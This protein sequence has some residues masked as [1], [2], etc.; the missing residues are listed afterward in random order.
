MTLGGGQ[1]VFIKELET[2][3]LFIGGKSLFKDT[4]QVDM[5][6]GF[7]ISCSDV[8]P[9]PGYLSSLCVSISAPGGTWDHS[10]FTSDFL[11]KKSNA[12]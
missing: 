8:K 2:D 6:G 7:L 9:G 5:S 1:F 10:T 4:L 11:N 12:L 3:I